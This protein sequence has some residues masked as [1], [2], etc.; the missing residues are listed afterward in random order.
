MPIRV[1]SHPYIGF[2]GSVPRK[3]DKRAWR[4]AAAVRR[5]HQRSNDLQHQHDDHDCYQHH[6]ETQHHDNQQHRTI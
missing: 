4:R 5:L 2:R 3:F 1:T 6:D